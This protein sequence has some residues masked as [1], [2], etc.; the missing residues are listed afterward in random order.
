MITNLLYAMNSSKSH[1]RRISILQMLDSEPEG[2]AVRE[3]SETLEVSKVTIVADIKHLRRELAPRQVQI[4]AED[5]RYKLEY[6]DWFN[7]DLL[8][9]LLNMNELPYIIME[10]AVMGR[11]MDINKATVL[12]Q[13]SRTKL[14]AVLEHMNTELSRFSVKISLKNLT[15]EGCE[16]DVR[17]VYFVF[18]SFLSDG[19][20]L[21]A[22]SA[23]L[24][25]YM[26]KEQK[27]R[28][29][30]PL[31]LNF[32]NLSIHLAIT[33]LRWRNHCYIELPDEAIVEFKA[34]EDYVEAS[35]IVEQIYKRLYPHGNAVTIPETEK[36]WIWISALYH[37]S[38]VVREESY[39]P[40]YPVKSKSKVFLESLNFLLKDKEDGEE[41]SILSLYLYNIMVLG[42]MTR[43][44][45]RILP[46][47][48]KAI[49]LSHQE[50]FVYWLDLLNQQQEETVF[51]F[52][53]K[54]DVA[55]SLALIQAN[56]E[57]KTYM[58]DLDEIHIV[59]ALQ[60]QPGLEQYI[61][62]V[63]K[64]VLPQDAAIKF[65]LDEPVTQREINQFGP[66]LIVSNFL[67]NESLK[68]E[69]HVVTMSKI[70]KLTDWGRM[71]EAIN[72]IHK[73]KRT[74]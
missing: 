5:D 37:T 55:A 26:I 23:A 6:P 15:L 46:S 50:K 71:R 8:C 1:C 36:Y 63:A 3:I 12:Y 24:A 72:K 34:C 56:L 51:Y 4:L 53:H 31:N 73:F 67:L 38:Y 28:F 20:S 14:M 33:A 74:L 70:P 64:D 39:I 17:F 29:K 35:Q 69:A 66:C 61:I 62:D 10:N 16:A 18:F 48:K 49:K 60:G 11:E 59:V 68:T 42:T 2:L 30:Q 54:E 58:N 21:Y 13:V 45:E 22:E 19:S 65:Y 52:E 7:S 47:L 43:N 40:D 27:K 57:R 41:K 32:S 44:Y 9:N 25:D